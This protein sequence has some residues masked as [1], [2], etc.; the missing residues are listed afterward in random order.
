VFTTAAQNTIRTNIVS[1]LSH[2]P[3]G[4]GGAFPGGNPAIDHFLGFNA[5]AIVVQVDKATLIKNG[6]TLSVWGGTY[7]AQ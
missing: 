2:A 1:Q 6:T 4:L 7:M 5:L 3:P